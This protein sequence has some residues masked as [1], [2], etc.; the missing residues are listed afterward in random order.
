MP[1]STRK[2][3]IKRLSG[4]TKRKIMSSATHARTSTKNRV[5]SYQKF[6][7]I[8]QTQEGLWRGF[9]APY[10]VTYEDKTKEKVEEV[11]PKLVKLYEEGL[12]KYNNPAHLAVVS[13]TDEED[14]AEFNRYAAKIGNK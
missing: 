14:I 12:K 1:L 6:T 4:Y 8:Y 9:V 3:R 7:H 2:S 11:L 13:L 5:D 10:D